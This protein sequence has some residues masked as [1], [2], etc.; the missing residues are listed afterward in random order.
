MD[1]SKCPEVEI[2]PEVMSGTP[3]V[4]GTR[5]PADA[6]VENANEGL[7]PE[8]IAREI[9]PTVSVASIRCVLEFANARPHAVHSAR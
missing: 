9:Y 1:W 2:K 3:V 7:S 4:K 8:L 5:V 6:I